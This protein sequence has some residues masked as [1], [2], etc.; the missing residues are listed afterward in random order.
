M[1]DVL[2]R[3]ELERRAAQHMLGPLE[4][5]LSLARRYREV[6]AFHDYI[7]RRARLV[8]P[9]LALIGVTAL[10]CGLAPVMALVGTRFVSALAGLLLA[11]VMLLGSLF[12]L[13]L[14][15][16]SWLEE[17]SLART[18]GHRTAREPKAMRW[19]RKKLGADLG[20]P[21]RVP[22]L[23]AAVFVALPFALLL[24]LAPVIAAILLALLAAAPVAFARL[25]P[26]S[27]R[28]P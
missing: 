10:A 21:P 28:R 5:A 7:G 17:R 8:I 14:V 9:V 2:D 26:P 27:R 6:D 3:A 15:F 23:L 25:D 18:L 24:K 4:D 13:G 16:F 20:R 1:R 11:P 22:W 12:V 19:L